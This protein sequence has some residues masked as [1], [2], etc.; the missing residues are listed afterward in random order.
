MRKKKKKVEYEITKL[1]KN[2]EKSS[3][4]FR[5]IDIAKSLENKKIYVR[6]DFCLKDDYPVLNQCLKSNVFWIA[7]DNWHI[8]L[9]WLQKIMKPLT[10]LF[11]STLLV[12][13]VESFIEFIKE[14]FYL[15][16][17][18]FDVQGELLQSLVVGLEVLANH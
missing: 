10:N 16:L 11:T 14:I 3:I 12:N 13:E 2:E 4:L 6:N 18:N 15:N 17:K 7:M 5:K 8:N 9:R 1:N